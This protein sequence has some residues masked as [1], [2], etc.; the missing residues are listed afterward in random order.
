MQGHRVAGGSSKRRRNEVMRVDGD[1]QRADKHGQ[2]TGNGEMLRE[3][4]ANRAAPD[5]RRQM[6]Q[7]EQAGWQTEQ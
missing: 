6:K 1:R 7:Q 3:V 4:S 5:R 2:Q